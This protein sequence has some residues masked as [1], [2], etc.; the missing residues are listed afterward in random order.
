MGALRTGVLAA[1]LP[2]A[3]LTAIYTAFLFG[4]AKGRDLWQSTLS[5]LHLLAQAILAGSA[6]LLV[7]APLAALP[8]E[9]VTLAWWSFA[10]VLVVDLVI[11]LPAEFAMPHGTDAASRASRMITRG[12]Y[13]RPFWGGAILLGHLA[14]LGVLGAIVAAAA[15]APV[16]GE[17]FYALGSV[18]WTAM[19]GASLAGALA[20]VLALMGL[21]AYE[22]V[23]VMAPQTLRNS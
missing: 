2:L 7:I 11:L 5:P 17:P 3:V 8:A 1:G 21:Y 20:G 15:L 23:W 19:S 6:V 12:R 18:P 13:R 14:P 4:Q 9:L 22:Y 16:P 10:V